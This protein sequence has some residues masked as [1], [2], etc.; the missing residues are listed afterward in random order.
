MSESVLFWSVNDAPASRNIIQQI[1]HSSVESWVSD[2]KHGSFKLRSS[3]GWLRY[4][5]LQKWNKYDFITFVLNKGNFLTKQRNV[6]FCNN[7]KSSSPKTV[8][9]ERDWPELWCVLGFVFYW[10]WRGRKNGSKVSV[11][12]RSSVGSDGWSRHHHHCPHPCSLQHLLPHSLQED[13]KRRNP[14]GKD[15]VCFH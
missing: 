2:D 9:I 10:Q 6:Q 5:A 14:Q 11:D 7:I 3:T 4:F 1:L 15:H 8:S 13:G 12:T